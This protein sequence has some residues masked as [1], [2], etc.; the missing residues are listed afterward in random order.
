LEVFALCGFVLNAVQNMIRIG[1]KQMNEV[2]QKPAKART[3]LAWVQ[4]TM[5][6]EAQVP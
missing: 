3:P 5:K 6:S 4:P 1:R 2:R